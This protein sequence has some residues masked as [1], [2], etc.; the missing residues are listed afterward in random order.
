MKTILDKGDEVKFKSYC[1]KHSQSRQKLRESEYP[2]HRASEQSQAKSEKTS[3]RAQK[4]RELEE[5]FYSMV[6]VED[7]ATELGLPMLIV[8]FIYNYW[9]L[10]RKSNFNKP[11]FPPKE[12]EEN[13]LVQPREESIHTRMRM[14][15]H[16]RQD[17]E[18]VRWPTMT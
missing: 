7:V 3:L 10:K 15:M 9:K 18:R 1:L 2:L 8:D 17:L 6:N 14:F 4:L 11:L 13:V 16:L 5:E 12:E